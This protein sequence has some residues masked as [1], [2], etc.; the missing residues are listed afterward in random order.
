MGNGCYRVDKKSKVEQENNDVSFLG[1]E[2]G[3]DRANNISASFEVSEILKERDISALVDNSRDISF[4]VS[5]RKLR[6]ITPRKSEVNASQGNLP[7]LG[8]KPTK[9]SGDQAQLMQRLLKR[10]REINTSILNK[11]YIPKRSI[12][13][14]P[15]LK[16]PK[17]SSNKSDSK[18]S[19]DQ[20]V[21]SPLITPKSV[22]NSPKSSFKP[23]KS[24]LSFENK[25]QTSSNSPHKNPPKP[26]IIPSNQDLAE[27]NHKP[28]ESTDKEKMADEQRKII[29][30]MISQG[31]TIF[32]VS[33][34]LS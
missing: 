25:P 6:N 26:D 32:S 2:M 16:T 13:Q 7:N 15:E 4:L 27:D 3:C 23:L 24:D 33:I 1:K 20:P 8:Q 10:K 22:Q 30:D 5:E 31:N 11:N 14:N 9:I 29:E 18:N 19:K 17:F 28:A 21:L 34:S 12:S